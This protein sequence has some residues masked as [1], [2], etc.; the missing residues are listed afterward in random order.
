M[1]DDVIGVLLRQVSSARDIIM[2]RDEILYRAE[3]EEYAGEL[4]SALVALAAQLEMMNV[5]LVA[6]LRDKRD[7]VP[8]MP[9]IEQAGRLFQETLDRVERFLEKLPR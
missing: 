3:G 4:S 1:S 8:L 9:S 5:I 2:H 7:M 6:P